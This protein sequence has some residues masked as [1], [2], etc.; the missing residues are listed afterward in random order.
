MTARTVPRTLRALFEPDPGPAAFRAALASLRSAS[1][2][3]QHPVYSTGSPKDLSA[4]VERHRGAAER[5]RADLEFWALEL[6]NLAEG[7]E[8]GP[9][10]SAEAEAFLREGSRFRLG[11]LLTEQPHPKTSDLSR[12]VDRDVEEGLRLLN[13]V[14]REIPPAFSRAAESGVLDPAVDA[15]AEAL[16]AGGRIFF[17]GCGATGRLSLLLESAWRGFWRRAGRENPE[18]AARAR[19]AFS[20]DPAERVLGALAGGDY[21]LIRSVEHFEDEESFGRQQVR[22]LGVGPGDVLFAVTE[23]GETTHVLGTAWEA[24]ERGARAFFVYNNPDEVLRGVERSARILAEPR[25]RKINLATGPQALTGSTRM[26]AASI[27]TLVLGCVLEA[28]LGRVLSRRLRPDDLSALGFP[29][30]PDDIRSA[31]RASARIPEWAAAA[32][33]ALARLARIEAR[34]YREGGNLDTPRDV[35]PARGFTLYL[36]GEESALVLLT[37]TTERSPTF[38]LPPFRPV[39][40]PE[41]KAPPAS[42]ILEAAT[43]EEAWCRLLGREIRALEWQAPTYRRLLGEEGF[44]RFGGAAPAIGREAV[45]RFRI[46]GEGALEERPLGRGNLLVAVGMEEDL[47]AARRPGS[48]LGRAFARAEAEGASRTW[49]VVSS[50]GRSRAGLLPHDEAVLVEGV[51]R[52]PLDLSRSLV[53]KLLLNSLSTIVMV[54][55]GRVRGNWMTYVLPTNGK[56]VDRAGRITASLSDLPYEEAVRL[57][58]S[59]AEETREDL[60]AGRGLPPVVN[61]AVVRARLGVSTAKATALLSLHRGLLAPTLEAAEAFGGMAARIV[62]RSL[63]AVPPG[64]RTRLL[65]ELRRALPLPGDLE[66]ALERRPE[67]APRLLA[68]LQSLAP[69]PEPLRFASLPVAPDRRKA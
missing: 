57:V 53:L 32:I 23:G 62:E 38:A 61:H 66:S 13:A 16:A 49:I 14:D 42:L 27:D 2:E 47:E 33:P 34:T 45:L 56:L 29:S 22:E 31:A 59:T 12:V 40:R 28:A 51:P 4:L 17:T 10:R 35:E 15:A 7:F 36:A 6:A 9:P 48:L 18:P 44:A 54:S 26:Q 43:N 30:P 65:A 41:A 19:A 55:L 11:H 60:R 25:I 20:S 5:I 69:L 50:R 37:D 39:D 21:A 8:D 63:E 64:E 3:P 52:S 24:L 67:A 1:T 46:G 68:S 58:L